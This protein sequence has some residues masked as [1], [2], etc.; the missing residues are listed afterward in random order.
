MLAEQEHVLR[1]S[2]PRPQ[3]AIDT[4]GRP[5]FGGGLEA[6][7][8]A[9]PR[10]VV[11][12][13]DMAVV[14]LAVTL[15]GGTRVAALAAA[16]GFLAGAASSRLYARRSTLEAQA[17]GWYLRLL[18]LPLL[19][20]A[21]G[22]GLVGHGSVRKLVVP[23]A[24][25]A[26]VLVLLRAVAWVFVAGDRRRGRGLRPVLLVGPP[27]R[28]SQVA[29]RI[30]AYPE[31]G[32]EVAATFAPINTN[33]DRSRARALLQAGAVDYVL[34][35]AEA[36]DSALLEECARWSDGSALDFGMVLP[37]GTGTQGGA[38]VGDLGI[39][40]LGSTARL[41]QRWWVKRAFDIAVSA[42][43][44]LLMAPVLLIV[45]LAIYLYDRGPVIYRQRRV[46]LHNREFTIWK[47]R[48]MVPGADQLN[49][50][51]AGSNMA[52]GLLFK[53][54]DDPRVTPVGNLIRRLSID[55]L[56]QLVNV[57]KGD[58]SL[59]GPRPLPVDPE[60]FDTHAARR[61]SVRPGITGPWQVAGGHVLAYEDMIKLDLAYVDSWS[62]RRDLWY[63]AMT[64]PTVMVRRSVY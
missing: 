33:G 20:M 42:A 52:N 11:V 57:L 27:A 3:A 53:L 61:H 35:S 41:R 19:T 31:A 43:L 17:L 64:I 4:P 28:T 26:A 15:A 6:F 59:V 48:S 60:E 39:V 21:A 24:V 44:L 16:G 30:E 22:L 54:S 45:S 36:H 62:L 46:G 37:V 8:R 7:H 56:P 32:L 49:E 51:Y 40:M 5:A 10:G 14:V 63:L 55:E 18:P 25:T 2:T 38:R 50:Q 34:V 12:A 9:S 47:F 13:I 29:R 23:L 1:L 58:M